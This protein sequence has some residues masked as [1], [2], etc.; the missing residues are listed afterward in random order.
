MGK[1]SAHASAQGRQLRQLVA[2]LAAKLLCPVGHCYVEVWVADGNGINAAHPLLDLLQR[3]WVQETQAVPQQI[4]ALCTGSMQ[5]CPGPLEL[6]TCI[7]LG[8]P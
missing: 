8:H 4:A 7:C 5:G 6:H 3:V 2:H 1:L